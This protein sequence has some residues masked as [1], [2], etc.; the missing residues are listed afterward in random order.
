M[1]YEVITYS[2]GPAVQGKDIVCTDSLPAQVLP[3]FKDCQVTKASMDAA[4]KGALINPCV[5]T[6]YSIHYTKLYD[7]GYYPYQFHV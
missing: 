2:I 4:N 5:I 6:S 3:D 1:L 7:Y